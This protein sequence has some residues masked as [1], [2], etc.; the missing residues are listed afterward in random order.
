MA[1]DRSN[2]TIPEDTKS[3]DDETSQE[4]MEHITEEL[5][6]KL[7]DEDYVDREENANEV[8]KAVVLPEKVKSLYRYFVFMFIQSVFQ[9]H[10]HCWQ[11]DKEV[12]KV[13]SSEAIKEHVMEEE[14]STNELPPV[15]RGDEANK[16]I[17]VILN[18]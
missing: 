1:E 3:Q 18:K 7:K 17:S 13:D 14:S 6:D 11:V 15:S 16:V 9:L 10:Y 12:E 8:T 2:E 4:T 5:K